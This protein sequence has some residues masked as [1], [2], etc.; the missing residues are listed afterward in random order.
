MRLRHKLPPQ[1]RLMQSIPSWV[2]PEAVWASNFELGRYWRSGAGLRPATSVLATTRSSGINLPNTAGE[3]QSLGN[4]VLPRTDRGLYANGQF[5]QSAVNWDAPA[6]ETISLGTGTFTL[7]VWGG[8]SIAVAAGTAAGSGFG[9]ATDGSPVT[10]TISGA[11]TVSLTV[12]GSPEYVSV[13]NTSFAPPAPQP[14]GT[15]LAS[16]IRAVQGVRPS[17][18]QAEPFAGWEAAGLDDGV[19]ILLDFENRMRQASARQVVSLRDAS[20]AVVAILDTSSTGSGF[21]LTA[22]GGS[23]T[24]PGSQTGG[25]SRAACRVMPDGAFALAQEGQGSVTTGTKASPINL[26]SATRL[27][28]GNGPALGQPWNDWIYGLQICKPLSD[29][30]LLAWVNT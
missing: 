21:R 2:A 1:S 10:F 4:N 23:D 8:G 6:N 15:V 9:T 3:Y 26:A 20:N 13:T 28:V 24:F 22:G 12:T 16:D 29:A 7:A 27:T 18:S 25:R 19:T 30:E 14:T 17:D 5:V 11:G